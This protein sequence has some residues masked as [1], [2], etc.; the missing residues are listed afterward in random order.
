MYDFLSESHRLLRRAGELAG[1]DPAVVEL[2]EE[3][4]RIV[5][6]RIPMRM[7]DGT[8]RIFQAYRVRHN[9]A[10]GPSRN[11][12][13]ISPGLDLDEVKA[14]GLLMSIKHAAGEIPAGGGKG[15]I[16]ADPKQLTRWEVERLCRAYVRHLR[17]SGPDYDV[18]GADIGTDLQSMAW[19]L[20]EFE[21]INGGHSPASIDDKPT[22]LGGSPGGY[23]ATGGG[24]FDMAR[25]ALSAL[26]L[27]PGDVTVAVQGFG[28]VASIA[29]ARFHAAGARVISVSDLG[30]GVHRK[31]GL[32]VEALRAHA[33]EAGTVAG[34]PGADSITNAELLVSDC[35]VLVPAAVQGVLT[36][37]NVGQV[38][39]RLVV[40][41][42]NAPTSVEA[43]DV[44][45]DR[46][47]A[48]VPDILANSGSV[49]VCQMERSQ[50]LSD[51]RWPL[52]EVEFLRRTRQLHAYHEAQRAAARHD[53]RSL[54]IG[55]WI[56]AMRRLE[57]AVHTRGWL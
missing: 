44:L 37:E 35:D 45:V 32:D 47:I 53:V 17:L 30:G 6:F 23:E 29:A 41:G 46:G 27:E 48:V 57:D 15:G 54:R 1:I 21:H 18:P 25:E 7:D 16:T 34:F 13:R 20:D 56:N 19:M 52:E 49:H 5:A 11:G 43:D 50:G 9:D 51:N 3:P 26:E 22:I 39:A 8:R 36:A 12:T 33:G 4:M 14:L 10:L 38:R 2:L 24:V 42:A 28:Q 55:A 40:E 31:D